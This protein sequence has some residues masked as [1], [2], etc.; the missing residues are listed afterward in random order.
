DYFNIRRKDGMNQLVQ[1]DVGATGGA[2]GSPMI[3]AEGEVVAV[4]SAVN[5]IFLNN[6]EIRIPSGASINFAQRADLVEELVEG[7]AAD[8][9]PTYEAQWREALQLFTG[10]RSVLPD[11]LL[12]DLQ[13]MLAT[14]AEPIVLKEA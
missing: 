3:N 11:L 2:S 4:L 7:T 13:S 12:S 9:L 6:G 8:R 1:H 10:F 14:E 5:F